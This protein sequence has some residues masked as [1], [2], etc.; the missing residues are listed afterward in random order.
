MVLHP[1]VVRIRLLLPIGIL[2]TFGSIEQLGRCGLICVRGRIL[3]T[4][5]LAFG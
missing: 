2:L 3:I 1:M 5:N 4:G